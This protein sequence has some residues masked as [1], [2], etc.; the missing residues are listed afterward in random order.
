MRLCVAIL[1]SG[2]MACTG[3]SSSEPIEIREYL[4][5]PQAPNG[6]YDA[7]PII[8]LGKVEVAPYLDHDGIVLETTP[9]E[10]NTA[11]HH[12]W[13]DPLNFAI[14]RYLQIEIGRA[15]GLDTAGSVTNSDALQTQIDVSVYQLHGTVSGSVKLVAEWQMRAIDSGEIQVRRQFSK[16]Q[17]IRGDGYAEVV[18]AHAALL[19]ELAA[20]IAA[21]VLRSE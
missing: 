17:T 10:L 9:G 2:V 16:T 19:D 4:L 15:A 5:R 13:A 12:R 18:R 11:Q 3:C 21:E 7:E 6:Q 8:G 1:L 14:R 20:V